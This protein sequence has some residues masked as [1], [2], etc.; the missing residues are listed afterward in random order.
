MRER[1]RFETVLGLII[2]LRSQ[3][4]LLRASRYF[5]CFRRRYDLLNLR[6][7]SLYVELEMIC[8]NLQLG[9]LKLTN[10]LTIVGISVHRLD[11]I[12]AVTD[13]KICIN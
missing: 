4:V 11:Y 6:A 1:E 5:Y 7:A 3:L 13:K 10:V 9:S 12:G 8:C 2:E